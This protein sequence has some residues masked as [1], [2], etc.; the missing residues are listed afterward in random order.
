MAT[1]KQVTV[2]KSGK[3]QDVFEFAARLFSDARSDGDVYRRALLAWFQDQVDGGNFLFNVSDA[4]L[5]TLQDL[6]M[7]KYGNLDHFTKPAALHFLLALQ[8]D[9]SGKGS[10]TAATLDTVGRVE[11]VTNAIASR[12]V[13][14]HN[15]IKARLDAIEKSLQK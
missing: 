5:R 10:T 1:E 3:M 11:E 2:S 6:W 13:S 7:K 8:G 4:E 12:Q 14:F 9:K 15:E